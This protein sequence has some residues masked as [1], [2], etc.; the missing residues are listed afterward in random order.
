[1]KD[2]PDGAIYVADWYDGQL[3]HTANYQGGLDRE[4]GRIYR[5]RSKASPKPGVH[6][7]GLP[8][9]SLG[10]MPSTELIGLLASPDRWHRETARRLLADRKDPS[11]IPELRKK[12]F[13]ATGQL[14]L[15]YLWALNLSKGL[16]EATVIET[17]DHTEPQ[18]RLW[19]VRLFADAHSLPSDFAIRVARLAI[20]EP[21]VEVRSQF[22][23]SAKRLSQDQAL[24]I[25]KNLLLHDEDLADPRQP[26]MIWWALEAAISSSSGPL[27]ISTDLKQR[28]SSQS[29][30]DSAALKLF[31]DKSL[32]SRPVVL[33]EILPR[34]MRRFASTGQRSD[35]AV[36][37]RLLHDSPSPETTKALMQGFEEAFQGRTLSNVPSELVAALSAAGGGSLSLKIRQGDAMAIDEALL[38]IQ[39]EKT[40]AGKRAEYASLFGEVKQ[41]KSVPILLGTLAQT[42]DDG[43]KGSILT[44]LQSYGD[45]E[46]AKAILAQYRNFNEDVRSVAQSLL[47]SR[48]AWA[49]DLANAVDRGDIAASSLPLDTVRR[50][51]I[52][53][54][55]HLASLIKKHWGQVEG[56]TSAEMQSL[57][58]RYTTVLAGAGDPYPGKKLYM[59][60][61]GKCH[62]L[63]AIGGKTGP[64]L[65][66]YK[67]DDVRQMLVHIVNPSA[68]IRE[69]FET[70]IAVLNDGR[71]VTGFLVEQDQQTVTL[72]S[73]DGQTVSLER[74]SLDEL[75]KSR[76]SLM[77]D[78]QLKDLSD[79]QLRNLFAYLRSSQPLND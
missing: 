30:T 38:A 72:R 4:N 2:G 70:Q 64:D 24:P 29:N 74:S 79:E 5:V 45:A 33:K 46:I 39:N 28:S 27:T 15:E 50:M 21:N 25:I 51:T 13:E 22:A 18:V 17:L 52:H 36:C 34:L 16:D 23:A 67:R 75:N 40:P 62:T 26:L 49:I 55:E 9:K 78:G 20:E 35:L 43:L 61:C 68:E 3:A 71:V 47:V 53:R 42:S 8:M 59:Q 60:M 65:T 63:H 41:P 32:W 7:P 69:G 48:K 57:I 54:D 58:E 6:I 11:V 76:K 56:A 37:A 73:P 77:P 19:A 44:A 10:N 66:T 1:M 14:A 31:D 12:L